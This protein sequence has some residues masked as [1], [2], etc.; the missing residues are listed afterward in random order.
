VNRIIVKTGIV[1]HFHLPHSKHTTY[2]GMLIGDDDMEES[3]VS[4]QELLSGFE[5]GDAV[6]ITIESFGMSPAAKGY[7]WMLTKP[8]VYERVPKE[9]G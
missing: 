8:H 4:L 6:K 1:R 2:D 9:D 3:N 7:H 5:D